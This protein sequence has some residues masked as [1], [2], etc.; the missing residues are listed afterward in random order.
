MEMLVLPFYKETGK[1][2]N[3]F[4][5]AIRRKWCE[6]NPLGNMVWEKSCLYLMLYVLGDDLENSKWLLNQVQNMHYI[7]QVLPF[8]YCFFFNLNDAPLSLAKAFL[9]MTDTFLLLS[10]LPCNTGFIN[11][12]TEFFPYSLGPDGDKKDFCFK[13]YL[14]AIL[15][16]PLPTK[17]RE[18]IN[19]RPKALVR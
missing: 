8:H 13:N 16:W 12:S 3:Y 9:S 15:S 7:T 19:L 1:T 6:V 17:E 4:S 2:H 11:V 5:C 10:I 14:P 18:R